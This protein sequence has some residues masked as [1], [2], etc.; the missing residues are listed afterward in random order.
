MLGGTSEGI[1]KRIPTKTPLEI[2]GWTSGIMPEETLEKIIKKR[3]KGFLHELSGGMI[4][5]IL[6][7]ITRGTRGGS[8]LRNS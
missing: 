1:H 8:L 4:E 2:P 3:L 7:K 6:R 5:G